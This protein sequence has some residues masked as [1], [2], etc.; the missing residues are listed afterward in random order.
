M[1]KNTYIMNMATGGYIYHTQELIVLALYL[2]KIQPD[3]VVNLNG[4]NDI[5]HS[6]RI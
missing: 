2:E 4:A 5:T 1:K 3:I 6:L